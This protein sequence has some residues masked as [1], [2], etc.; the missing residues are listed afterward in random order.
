MLRRTHVGAGPHTSQ[1]GVPI[2]GEAESIGAAMD[3]TWRRWQGWAD[4]Q[5]PLRSAR[6]DRSASGVRRFGARYDT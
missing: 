3:A 5:K 1:V 6:G 4:F 2:R